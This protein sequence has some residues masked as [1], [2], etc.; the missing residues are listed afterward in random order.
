M[1]PTNNRIYCLSCRRPKMLFESEAKANNFIKFNRADILKESHRAPVRSYYC[2][3]CGG[4]HVTS[5]AS[6]EAA[7]R[8]DKR[9]Q[10]I[11][12]GLTT[13]NQKPSPKAARKPKTCA[14]AGPKVMKSEKTAF[15]EKVSRAYDVL[16][17]GRADAAAEL[18]K[19]CEAER[20]KF[21]LSG[22][23]F[24]IVDAVIERMHRLIPEVSKV[25]AMSCDE[26][27]CFIQESHYEPEDY[28]FLCQVLMNVTL[29]KDVKVRMTE[30]DILLRNGEFA[31][32][33]KK[34]TECQAIVKQIQS[35]HIRNGLMR[36]TDIQL[37]RISDE[38][39]AK[40]LSRCANGDIDNED[41]RRILR[42]L[43]GRV[44]DA[45]RCFNEGDIEACRQALKFG[46]SVLA[47]LGIVD[48]NTRVVKQ[49]LDFWSA[50]LLEASLIAS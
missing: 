13:V 39:K 5:N 7:E 3:L 44:E 35:G 17:F 48:E 28:E 11:F 43:I 36:M 37:E 8:M 34:V 42:Y 49:Y 19:E 50:Q 16:L 47:D 24:P 27:D 31:A 30:S 40:K 15:K 38:R 29:M 12:E 20:D 10:Q 41:Y 22:V 23:N 26:A 32:A 46:Y 9:D 1:K 45:E 25:L 18:I 33:R 21:R 4:Y 6:L 14:P 2:N